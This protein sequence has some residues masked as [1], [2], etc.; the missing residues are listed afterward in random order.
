MTTPHEFEDPFD[1][2]RFLTAQEPVYERALS[3]VTGGRKQSHWMWYIFPQMIG[4]GY[5]AMAQRYGIR[6]ADE[7]RAYLQHPVLGKRLIECAAA[8]NA[9]AG[10]SARDIFGEPDDR[11][12]QSC[13]TLFAAVSEPDSEERQVF[14]NLLAKYYHGAR[15][16]R[17]LSLLE[18]TA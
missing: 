8:V 10:R 2:R 11:K 16:A 9:V 18:E 5:S 17:T 3:E 6:S 12:L 15:D 13:A 4:L 1:L 7:A 14:D